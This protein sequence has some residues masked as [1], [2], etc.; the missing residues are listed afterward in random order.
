M[1][2]RSIHILPLLPIALM[3]FLMTGCGDSDVTEGPCTSC[4]PV[5]YMNVKPS[6][7]TYEFSGNTVRLMPFAR[8]DGQWRG[9]GTEGACTLA[10]GLLKC[11]VTDAGQVVVSVSGR[12]LRIGFAAT[13]AVTVGGLA[14]MGSADI[15]DAT[16]WLSNGF[17]SWS[18]SGMIALGPKPGDDAMNK[19]LTRWA[20]AE[21][22]REG[23]E[24][25]WWYSYAGGGENVLFAGA[26]ST[27]TFK[28]WVQ[29]TEETTED[30]TGI[31]V[32]MGNGCTGEAIVLAAGDTLD[33]D[34]WMLHIG[35]DAAAVLEDYGRNLPS[36][37]RQVETRAGAGWNSWYELWTG[38][39]EEAVLDN[40]TKAGEALDGL[41]P[42]DI[43]V[44][45]VID[46]GWEKAWGIWEA[47]EK[48][49]SGMDGIA[50][51]LKNQ[52]FEVGIW[53]APFMVAADSD[54]ATQ[55]PDWF[56]E[57]YTYAIIG[58]QPN[59]ILDVTNPQAA[60]HLKST[61]RT[62]VGWGYD[63]LKIDFLFGQTVE[64]GRDEN[65]T[66]MQAYHRGLSL[67]R[68]AAGEDVVLVAVGAPPLPS[69]PYADGWRLGSDIAVSTGSTISWVFMVN[70]ARFV[71]S[72]WPLCY[73]TLCDADPVMLRD[74]PREQINYGS[75][76]VAM[77]GGAMFLSDDLR[78]LDAER[79]AWGLDTQK[80]GYATGGVPAVPVDIFPASPPEKLTNQIVDSVMDRSNNVLPTTWVMPDGVKVYLN[81]G[82]DAKMVQGVTIPGRGAGI[83]E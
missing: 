52:G 14:F 53:L 45:I 41:L 68:E 72:R 66:G 10:D 70:Q 16:S 51:N 21:V 35:N 50:Q 3:F 60:E 65:V 37:R 8:I 69:F 46:D 15:S 18:Q 62:I 17:Q 6:G 83:I 27:D 11:P 20:D 75:W 5:G 31:G 54:L 25:S 9:G 12:Y 43:P 36:R 77:A 49:P 56:I 79:Y 82:D 44:R 59:V 55:H 57:G 4:G 34:L 32:I 30:G 76:V 26:M 7:I 58:G 71:A 78:S 39:T 64:G 33:G 47:N 28:A 67:I 19:A 61:I 1:M 40:A 48:F 80:T 73:A 81:D 42:A 2:R 23:Q 38:V 22:M 63:F 24:L 13:S 74:L 29:F